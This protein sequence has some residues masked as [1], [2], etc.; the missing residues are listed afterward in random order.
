MPW[1][2]DGEKEYCCQE[3]PSNCVKGRLPKTT[4]AEKDSQIVSKADIE[5]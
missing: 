4:N 2:N 1:W 5:T 3:C